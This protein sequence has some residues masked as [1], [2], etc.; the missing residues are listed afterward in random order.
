MRAILY[1]SNAGHTREYAQIF[2][3]KTGLPVYDADEAANKLKNGNE[4]IFFGWVRAGEITGYEK[5]KKRY[6]IKAVC[7]VGMSVPSEKTAEELRNKH[8]ITD[9]ELFYLQGGFDIRRLRGIYKFMMKNMMKMI[10][11]EISKKEEK[12]KEDEAY[13][14]MV[15]T[16]KNYVNEDNLRPI[17]EWYESLKGK[18]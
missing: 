3:Q 18:I 15:K 4:I 7:A 14:E 11:S 6:A 13:L 17:S 16:G 2:G 9:A 1:R 5:F 8:H 12:T 10:K